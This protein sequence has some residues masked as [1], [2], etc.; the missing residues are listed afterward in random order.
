[1]KDEDKQTVDRPHLRVKVLTTSELLSLIDDDR[2]YADTSHFHVCEYCAHMWTHTSN[3]A[4]KIG[5]VKAH[6]CPE[7]HSFH[8]QHKF[9]VR[10][11]QNAM[12]LQRDVIK[13]ATY[14]HIDRR[15]GLIGTHANSNV[16]VD[17][18]PAYDE[19]PPEDMVE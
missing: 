11:L 19:I 4:L 17:G 8:A 6:I 12:A 18:A 7:C 14:N 13:K 5:I 9:N 2:L 3:E 1:M 10:S 16:P 15:I